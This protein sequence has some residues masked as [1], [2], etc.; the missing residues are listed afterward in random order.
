MK[1]CEYLIIGNKCKIPKSVIIMPYSVIGKKYRKLLTG[2]FDKKDYTTKIG[3]DVYIGYSCLIGNGSKIGNFSILDDK[4]V[5]ES[6]V[7]IGEKTLLIYG[8]HVCNEVKI[9]NSC[10][11]GGLVGERTV[12][13]ND[14]RIF[15]KIIH[16]QLEPLNEWDSDDS[17]EESAEIYDKVFV[18]FNS[19]VVGSVKIGPRAYICAGSI[20]TKNVPEGHIAK[21]GFNEFIHHS[22]VISPIKNSKIF[23]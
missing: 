20:I 1:K 22:K 2:S 23:V 10:V 5:I 6:D 21:P 9:G 8:A 11:I 13:G 18:G 7:K 3:K 4:S 14:C 12:I 15:G 19:V 16:T 17:K